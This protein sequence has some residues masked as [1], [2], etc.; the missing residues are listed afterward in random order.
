MPAATAPVS[1][2]RNWN[3]CRGT[4]Q[5]LAASKMPLEQI[6]R[7]AQEASMSTNRDFSRERWRRCD[8]HGCR[9]R[10][11]R[12]VNLSGYRIGCSGDNRLRNGEG[13]VG[14]GSNRHH[15]GV[16][17]IGPPVFALQHVGDHHLGA[18]A[19]ACVPLPYAP[20]RARVRPPSNEV[21]ELRAG[22]LLTRCWR[23]MD[24]NYRSPVMIGGR[25]ST[26]GISG[27]RDDP[28][29]AREG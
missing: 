11:S 5:P 16:D 17:R 25:F 3:G 28:H 8:R 12:Q 15:R 20:P 6:S 4:W 24:S 21:A 19:R 29:L 23:E 10:A 2:R 26:K 18:F 7:P 22:L 14:Q 1:S 27:N 13:R 9:P